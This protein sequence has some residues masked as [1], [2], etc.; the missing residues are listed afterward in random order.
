MNNRNAKLLRVYPAGDGG[1]AGEAIDAG[2]SA[3][4]W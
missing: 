1:A 3:A 4:I 2:A